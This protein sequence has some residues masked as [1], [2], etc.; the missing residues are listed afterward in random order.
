M[1]KRQR[2]NLPTRQEALQRGLKR[3]RGKVCRKHPSL[4]GERMMHGACVGCARDLKRSP[5]YL[6]RQRAYKRS[7][8][9][10]ARQRARQTTP[11][12][13]ARRNARNLAR[14]I[15]NPNAPAVKRE[16]EEDWG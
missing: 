4:K 8:E 11:D 5:K 7:P 3:Y 9:Y 2:R 12:F 14:R 10:L 1:L 13:C 16:A 15:K 6:A